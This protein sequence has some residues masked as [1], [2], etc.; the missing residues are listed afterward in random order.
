MSCWLAAVSFDVVNPDQSAEF[1]SAVLKREPVEWRDGILVPGTTTQLGLRF[2]SGR[3]AERGT[4]RLHLHLTSASYDDQQRIAAKVLDLGGA[5]LDVGQ[6]SDESHIVLADPGDNAFCVI[7]PNSSF[8]AGCGPLGEVACDGTRDLGLFWASALNWPL[9]WDENDETAVQHPRGGTKVAWGGPPL[10]P[11]NGPNQQR[12]ELATN[13]DSLSAEV[14]R[15]R[16]LGATS[17]RSGLDG[18]VELLDP[19]GNEFR[20]ASAQ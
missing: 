14:E 1:W 8:L 7:G 16:S 10:A 3:A 9:V 5:H 11:K 13:R 19:D 2:A 20:L 17:A 18:T 4:R 15:L 6:R 12:F